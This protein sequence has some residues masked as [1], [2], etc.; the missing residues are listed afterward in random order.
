MGI[1]GGQRIDSI[2]WVVCTKPNRGNKNTVDIVRPIV[3]GIGIK[4]P[5]FDLLDSVIDLQLQHY[6]VKRD[7]RNVFDKIRVEL[8]RV[9][10][11]AGSEPD[12]CET[13]HFGFV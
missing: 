2:L 7:A 10:V 9:E 1:L 4:Q 3:A 5:T 13:R 12:P 8:A 11:L 6:S